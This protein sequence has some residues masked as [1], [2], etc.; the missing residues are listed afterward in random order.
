MNE[1][2]VERGDG[3]IIVTLN[4]PAR[5]NAL[6]FALWQELA[7]LFR[8]F[9]GD[10][11]ARTVILTGAGTFCAG[12]D[13]SEFSQNRR[14]AEQGKAYDRAVDQCSAAIME[15]PLPTIAAIS[16]FCVGGGCALALACDFRLAETDARLG[17]PAA[18]LGIVY[19][20][21][22]TRNLFHAVGLANAKR[23]LYSG[24]LMSAAEARRIGLVQEVVEAPVL[25]AAKD[26]AAP[27]IRNAPLSLAGSKLLLRGLASGDGAV[28][29]P[30]VDAAVGRALDS[31]DYRNAV[32]AFNNKR[33]P[34]FRGR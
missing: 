34:V 26:F 6:T 25:G 31:E 15:L 20:I 24:E 21:R 33:E 32:A 12:A 4:R 18:R 8:S 19:T 13:I 27:F 2:L 30:E 23:M 9:A 14:N 7:A 1:I 3:L 11:E 17:I 28:D 10:P 22:D 29:W 5:R 16:G